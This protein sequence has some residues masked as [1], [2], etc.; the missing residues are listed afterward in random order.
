[1]I[2]RTVWVLLLSAGL[3]LSGLGTPV[4]GT[5]VIPPTVSERMDGL[6]LGED[7]AAFRDRVAALHDEGA[8]NGDVRDASRADEV[9]SAAA[10]RSAPVPTPIPFSMVGFEIPAGTEVGFRTSGDG[11]TWSAWQWAPALTDT[12]GP[13]EGT[14]EAAA[15]APAGTRSGGYWV[16]EASWLQVR[17]LNGR[18]EDVGVDLID[19]LGLS[20]SL[21]QRVGDAVRAALRPTPEPAAAAPGRPDIVTRREWGADESLRG[22]S[23]DYASR[24]RM[25]VVHHTATRNTYSQEEAPGVVRAIY[26]YH[27]ESNGWSDIGYNIL[28]DRFGTVYE[29][30]HGGLESTVIGAHSRNWNT[31]TFGASVI[32]CFD[33]SACSGTEGGGA[34][35]PEAAEKALVEVLAW[36]LDVHSIDVTS[37]VEMNGTTNKT[38][39][40]HRDVGQTSCPGD[41]FYNQLGDIRERVAARQVEQGGVVLD[42]GASPSVAALRDGRLEEGITVSARLRPPGEWQLEA[43]DPEGRVVH[44]DSGAGDVATTRWMGGR[45]VEDGT[46]T[47]AFASPG[48]RTATGTFAVSTPC[49]DAFCDIDGSVHAE[50]ILRLHERGVVNGCAEQRFCPSGRVTRGQMAT[51][52]ARALDL[53]PE[54]GGHFTDVPAGHPHADGINA[55]YEHGIVQGDDGRFLPDREVRRDQMATFIRNGLGFEAS[56]TSHFSDVEGN[57]HE[58][59]INALA[60]HDVTRGDGTGRYLPDRPIRRDQI[61]SLLDRALQAAP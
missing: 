12:D 46:Y 30:R 13:D 17:V 60:D 26:R 11:D 34:S 37:T 48:R 14:R 44:R 56:G 43:T 10:V 24:V 7:P 19:S 27:T 38:L 59:A 41:R 29:G 54:S 53:E 47:Y 61:A 9:A 4:S 21:P 50:A 45:E 15:A 22:D 25:G 58:A 35:L 20:R 51:M 39:I 49:E 33:S 23:P 31:G 32:G 57:T 18:P 3:L 42:P 52:T 6:P 16:G 36:K 28:I 40:G 2:N 1:M 5:D 8:G 55:L